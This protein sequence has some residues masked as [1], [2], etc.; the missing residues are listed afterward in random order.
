VSQKYIFNLEVLG[1]KG[2]LLEIFD[3]LISNMKCHYSGQCF[4]IICRYGIVLIYLEWTWYSGKILVQCKKKSRNNAINNLVIFPIIFTEEKHWQ[5]LEIHRWLSSIFCRSLNWINVYSIIQLILFLKFD[6][7]WLFLS[8]SFQ[9]GKKTLKIIWIDIIEL[10]CKNWCQWM[11]S[12]VHWILLYMI[13]GLVSDWMR[14]FY[15]TDESIW[16]NEIY[17]SLT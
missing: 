6:H 1:K 8:H 9:C 11:S 3:V 13:K 10:H 15:S 2:L 16:K 17:T 7:E 12:V 14:L 5:V 4:A